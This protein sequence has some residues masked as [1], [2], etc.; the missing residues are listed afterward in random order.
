MRMAMMVLLV[1]SVMLLVP[2]TALR[3]AVRIDKGVTKKCVYVVLGVTISGPSGGP[4]PVDGGNRGRPLLA[5]S[6]Q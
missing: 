6:F 3:V 2:S 1:P 5:Q 4:R